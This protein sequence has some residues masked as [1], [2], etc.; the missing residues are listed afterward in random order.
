[1]TIGE[2][3]GQKLSL[4]ADADY[5]AAT[6]HYTVVKLGTSTADGTTAEQATSASDIYVGVLQNRPN[7]GQ[8]AEIMVTGVTFLLVDS[9]TDIGVGDSIT[10][11]T[12]GV[13]IKTT[14]AL[15]S[16]IGFALAARTAN[17]TGL[18]PV[19]L[20]GPGASFKAAS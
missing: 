19:L 9:T 7:T 10:A 16:V 6:N 18:I 14:T 13:G 3:P 17:D 11:T 2:I 4:P 20:A 5:S 8:A 12:A 15:N 1:M